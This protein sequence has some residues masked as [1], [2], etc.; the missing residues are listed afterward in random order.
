MTDNGHVQALAKLVRYVPESGV[1]LLVEPLS[2]YTS[3]AISNKAWETY[4]NPPE[5]E[6]RLPFPESAIP[7]DTKPAKDNPEYVRLVNAATIKRSNFIGEKTLLLAVRP[8]GATVSELIER[9]AARRKLLSQVIDLPDDPWLATL[10]HCICTGV[11]DADNIHQIATG[12]A[13]LTEEEIAD[14]IR[15][16]RLDVPGQAARRAAGQASGVSSGAEDQ[17]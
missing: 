17:P 15:F 14:G 7:N 10:I 13:A 16:F 3:I 11:H 1:P 8:D 5:E 12:K 9:F 4:P 6:Y 2:P